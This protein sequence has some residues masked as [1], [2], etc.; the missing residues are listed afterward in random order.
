MWLTRMTLNGRRSGTRRLLSNPQHMHA[1]VQ[2]AF[3]E[4]DP[5]RTLWRI[6]KRLPHPVLWLVSPEVPDLTHVAEQAA[7]PHLDRQWV[8]ASY[9]PLLKQLREGDLYHYRITVNPS[10]I[11]KGRRVVP[12]GRDAINRWWA[13]R[14]TAAG[15]APIRID[16]DFVEQRQIR[17]ARADAHVTIGYATFEGQA[18]VTDPVALRSALTGGVGRGKAYGCGLLTLSR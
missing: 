4:R 2:S 15:L 8:S 12:Q 17:F 9:L 1:A 13:A 10:S 3:G 7:W 16:T 14:A 6:D 5:G 18:L 11:R